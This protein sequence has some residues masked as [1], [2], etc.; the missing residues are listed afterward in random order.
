MIWMKNGEELVQEVEYG[1]I[2]PSGDGTY[3]TW[4]SVE[5]DPQS[6]DIYSCHVEHC[7][8]HMVLQG[9]QGKD[10]VV[11]LW[12][13][14]MRNKDEQEAMPAVSEGRVH[15][16]PTRCALEGIFHVSGSNTGPKALFYSYKSLQTPEFYLCGPYLLL[17]TILQ[18]KNLKIKTQ[19][20][21][22]LAIRLMRSDSKKSSVGQA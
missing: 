2:L 19:A 6:R 4:V 17:F 21:S 10:E 18:M 12:R 9:P 20:G 13:V 8:H 7:G 1:D 5:L 11:A 22:P 16:C 3:Q 15:H 14:R